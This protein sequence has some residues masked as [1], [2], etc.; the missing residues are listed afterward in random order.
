MNETSILS[1]AHGHAYIQCSAFPIASVAHTSDFFLHGTAR[2]S[3]KSKLHEFS[4]LMRQLGIEQLAVMID[5]GRLQFR[6]ALE[7]ILR[8][9]TTPVDLEAWANEDPAESETGGAAAVQGQG[10]AE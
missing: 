2:T 6:D 9:N 3:V 10:A 7:D 8:T 4:S 1:A 5:E